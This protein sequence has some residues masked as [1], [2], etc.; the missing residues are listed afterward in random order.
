MPK[1]FITLMLAVVLAGC[2]T[3][4]DAAR[5][6]E[7]DLYQ[8]A[9]GHLNAS[10][11][12]QAIDSLEEI[13]SRFPFGP[14]ARNAQLWTIYAYLKQ[15]NEALARTSADR[16]L[17]L[18]PEDEFADYALYLRGLAS[19]QEGF[20]VVSRFLPGN[21]YNRDAT[22]LLEAAQDFRRLLREYP[23]SPYATDA[24]LRLIYTRQRLAEQEIE[25]ATYYV[26]RGAWIAAA[27]RASVVIDN[28]PSAPAVVDALVIKA[29]AS[30]ALDEPELAQRALQTLAQNYPQY[31]V[32]TESGFDYPEILKQGQADWLSRS[33][34]G[35]FG[36]SGELH[37][38]LV[39]FTESRR[40]DPS[41]VPER[42]LRAD[43][44]I[45]APSRTD[46]GTETF[47]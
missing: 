18:N 25:V 15:S 35:L 38:R 33:S 21:N 16:F 14:Y 47:F 24:R 17:R 36:E 6:S 4:R 42:T 5:E 3:L 40:A 19:F 29:I 41:L 45:R 2:S 13:D 8:T 37:E 46:G 20:T 10:R 7:D 27:N 34:F 9:I 39:A 32:Q 1:Y 12:E 11:W 22:N 44:D 43:A 31:V 30:D 23:D 28:F 26:E